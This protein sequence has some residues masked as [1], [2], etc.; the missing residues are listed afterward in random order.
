METAPLTTVHQ[1][2]TQFRS[3]RTQS[4]E[5]CNEKRRLHNDPSETERK[6]T[7]A[8]TQNVDIPHK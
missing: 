5:K 1:K 2:I 4:I 8:R 6:L 3:E 7:I